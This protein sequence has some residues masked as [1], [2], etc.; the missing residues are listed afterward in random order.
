M[1]VATQIVNRFGLEVTD[2]VIWR[3][4]QPGEEYTKT[5]TLKNIDIK[6]KKLKF[7][8]ISLHLLICNTMFYLVVEI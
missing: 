3:R 4:W 5:I 8:Y 2:T 6:T 1:A 7:K